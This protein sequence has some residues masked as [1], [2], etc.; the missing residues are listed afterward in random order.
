MLPIIHIVPQHRSGRAFVGIGMGE[1]ADSLSRPL[2]SHGRARVPGDSTEPGRDGRAV[3]DVLHEDPP[4]QAAD[5][6]VVRLPR[7][8]RLARNPSALLSPNAE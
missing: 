5:D 6:Y 8:S 7:A 3:R 1:R 2:I 4:V